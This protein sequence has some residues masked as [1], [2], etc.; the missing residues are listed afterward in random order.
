ME[1]FVLKQIFQ[2]GHRRGIINKLPLIKAPKDPTKKNLQVVR[3]PTF[4]LD[5]WRIL[6]SYMREWVKGEQV[7]K[8]LRK[9]G[10]STDTRL[11]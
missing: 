7:A 10:I 5:E 2:W 11:Q 1:Q 4:E 9:N 8:Q 3:R 6:Y